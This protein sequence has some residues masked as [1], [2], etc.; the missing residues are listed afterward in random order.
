MLE[1]I[2]SPKDV[3]ELTNEERVVLA[4]DIRKALLERFK[5]KGGH[6]GPNFGIVDLTIALHTVFNSP[7][8]KFVFDVSHQSYPHKMLTGRREAFSVKEH[9]D[10][11]SGY[12][13]P[14]ESE[15][16]MFQ[17]GHT[18]TSIS[19]ALGLAKARDL[20]G[21]KYNVVAIIGDGSLSGGEALEGLNVAGEMTTNFIIIVN[22]NDMSISENH[23]GLYKSLKDLRETEGLSTNNLFRAMGLDYVFSKDGNNIEAMVEVLDRVK[24]NPK[25]VVVHVVTQKGKGYK[26]AEENKEA[27]HWRPA[28]DYL[29]GE[30]LAKGAPN[31]RT[32]TVEFLKKKCAEDPRVIV[33]AA[34]TAGANAMNKATREGLGKQF[35]DVGIAE[36]TAIALSSGIA[37]NGGKPVFPIF[38]TFLQRT[39]DQISQDVCINK[40]PVTIIVNGG[41]ITTARDVTHSGIYDISMLSGIPNLVYLA[42][43]TYEEYFAML[44]WS[45]DQD[46]Y[47]VAIRTPE[48]PILHSS[49]KVEMDYS[50]LNKAE[51]VREGRDV[52]IIAVGNMFALSMDVANEVDATVIN[53]RYLTGIDVNLLESI[54]KTHKTIITLEDGSLDGGYGERIS[55]FFGPYA[56]RVKNFGIKKDFYDLYNAEEIKSSCGLTKE[57]IVAYI[58]SIK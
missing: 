25:P 28:F 2:N 37:K 42:P 3:K 11:L 31:L 58:D 38:S 33:L 49:R 50:N 36:E 53:P 17:V 56:I 7:V 10:D 12:T 45:I 16:D 14:N 19:L 8:D 18:S 52:A 1:R 39:Y 47:P 51:V 23:G 29:T 48:G 54:A 27:Y 55:S 20:K 5:Y 15:H 46:K 32:D 6:F 22:D 13:N 41:S 57:A 21:E 43:T 34:G 44:D 35:I 26:P 40:S 30:I 24:D 4:E 9:Y